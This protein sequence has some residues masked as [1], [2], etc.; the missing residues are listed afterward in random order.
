MLPYL[1]PE[2]LNIIY[3]IK[4]DLENYDRELEMFNNFITYIINSFNLKLTIMNESD[5][6]HLI[7]NIYPKFKPDVKSVKILGDGWFT[8]TQENTQN[9]LSIHVGD[10]KYHLKELFIETF[11]LSSNNY[12][13][14]NN[15]YQYLIK[16]CRE[17]NM[18]LSKKFK[19]N[20]F[21]L[22]ETMLKLFKRADDISLL[23]N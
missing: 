22:V 16:N 8:D 5:R 7:R 11:S 2:I 18:D 13:Y 15:L 9:I 4:T 20:R 19:I 14:K 12:I 21:Q 23:Y 17:K 6:F 1:P 10:I 3:D